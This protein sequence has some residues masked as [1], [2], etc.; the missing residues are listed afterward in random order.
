MVANHEDYPPHG[1]QSHQEC[2][3]FPWHRHFPRHMDN[4]EDTFLVHEVVVYLRRFVH[5][6]SSILEVFLSNPITNGPSPSLCSPRS[7]SC[8]GR[9][10]QFPSFYHFLVVIATSVVRYSKD[11]KVNDGVMDS[12][13]AKLSISHRVHRVLLSAKKLSAQTPSKDDA[14]AHQRPNMCLHLEAPLCNIPID[15]FPCPQLRSSYRRCPPLVA[16]HCMPSFISPSLGWPE[17]DRCLTLRPEW[18]T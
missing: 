4:R 5:Q 18:E 1:Q 8:V 3:Q 14:N 2:P 11:A 12:P 13:S 10:H 9:Y 16:H 7:P 17:F 6:S 15:P